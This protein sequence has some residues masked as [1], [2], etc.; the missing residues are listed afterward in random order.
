MIWVENKRKRLDLIQKA[1]PDAYILDI[2]SSSPF[3]YGVVLSPFFP[4]GGIPVPGDSRGMTAMSVESIWQGLKIFDNADVDVALFSNESMKG[5]KRTVRKYGLPIGHR[6]GVFSERILNYQDAKRLIYLPSYKY[7]LENIPEVVHILARIKEQ[8]N[9][10][11]IVLLDYNINP[12]N[13]HA[14][15]PL[16]HAELVKS[17]IE[18]RYPI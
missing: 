8:A 15:K 2:T 17:Y 10:S 5:L 14:E 9:K 12:G 16:S 11:D 13:H 18:D 4:H 6:Y 3:R 1:H 7:V